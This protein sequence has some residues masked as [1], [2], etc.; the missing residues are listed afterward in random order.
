MFE[1]NPPYPSFSQ[2]LINFH[3]ALQ[4]SESYDYESFVQTS[5]QPVFSALFTWQNFN[6][7]LQDH[8]LKFKAPTYFILKKGWITL[9][10]QSILKF[11][12]SLLSE[13]GV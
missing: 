13:Y 1:Q 8:G 4:S 11:Q 10:S 3:P 9:R 2:N 12:T 6:I 7:I 5:P